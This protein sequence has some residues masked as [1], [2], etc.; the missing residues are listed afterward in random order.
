L[1]RGEESER[2]EGV[3]RADDDALSRE[4]RDDRAVTL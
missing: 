1:D 4:R 2:Y 3:I